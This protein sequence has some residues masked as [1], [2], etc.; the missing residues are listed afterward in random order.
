MA[1]SRLKT[2]NLFENKYRLYNVFAV[3][4]LTI[5][6]AYF[7]VTHNLTAET[8]PVKF[9]NLTNSDIDMILAVKAEMQQAKIQADINN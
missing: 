8:E 9:V 4:S 7:V 2:M 3:V 1:Y 6:V 5:A